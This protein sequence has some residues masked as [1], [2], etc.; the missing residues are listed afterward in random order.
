M[1]D[2][3]ALEAYPWPGNIREL[4]NVIESAVLLSSGGSLSRAM[5]PPEVGH[6]PAP[7]LAAAGPITLVQGEE[8]LIRR[9]LIASGGNLIQSARSL[10]IAKSTL[11]V[12]MKRYGMSRED[13]LGCGPDRPGID[14][15]DA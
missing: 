6:A 13:T 10:H 4:R 3:T 7:V 2:P 9:S 1:G 11:Y 8:D 5:L 15:R 14:P 12:K